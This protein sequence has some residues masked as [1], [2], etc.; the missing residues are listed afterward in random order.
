MLSNFFNPVIR[1][2]F[3]LFAGVFSAQAIYAQSSIIIPVTDFTPKAINNEGETESKWSVLS[4]PRRDATQYSLHTQDSLV[5]IKAESSNSASGLVYQVDINP[6]EYPIIEWSWQIEAP[7]KD[8][9]YKTKDGDDYAARIYITFD[10]DKSNLSFGDR[11]KYNA[12]KTFSRFPIPIRAINY[13]WANNA[14]IDTIAPNAYTDWVYMIVAETGN[15]RSNTWVMQTRNIFEDYKA[16][17]GEV[18]PNINGVAIMTDTDNT[19]NSATAFYGDIIFRKA[20]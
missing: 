11:L 9:N 14:D 3:F 19:K 10:Y 4:F 1:L 7:V 12:L 16:A 18:P 13:I 20:D 5:S 15:E 6:A 8:G 2:A 17:F